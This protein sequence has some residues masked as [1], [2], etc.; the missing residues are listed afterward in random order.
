MHRSNNKHSITYC[1]DKKHAIPNVSL[2]VL[3]FS[4]SPSVVDE[5]GVAVWANDLLPLTLVSD[6]GVKAAPRVASS[7]SKVRL[8]FLFACGTTG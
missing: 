1:M 4:G 3:L 2:L 8:R 6:D 5:R 7:S